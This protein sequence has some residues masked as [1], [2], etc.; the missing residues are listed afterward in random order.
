MSQQDVPASG[1]L[2]FR[3]DR[4]CP[5]CLAEQINVIHHLTAV[6]GCPCMPSLPERR[7]LGEHLDRRCLSC[8]Y[9]WCERVADAYAEN[10][11]AEGEDMSIRKTAAGQVLGTED[12]GITKTAATAWEAEDEAGLAEENDEAGALES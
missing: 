4:C 5:K 12:D 10:E 1:L 11:P 9:S 3:L 2:D 8:G 7:V 6:A